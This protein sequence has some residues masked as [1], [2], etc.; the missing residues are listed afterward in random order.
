MNSGKKGRF[1][2]LVPLNGLLPLLIALNDPILLITW[3]VTALALITWVVHGL[4]GEGKQ[5]AA[6]AKR[7]LRRQKIAEL[8]KDLGYEPL[9]LHELDDILMHEH[10]QEKKDS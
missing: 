7:Q 4:A 9:N 6:D 1:F 8:E 5:P 2:F 10:K 3:I